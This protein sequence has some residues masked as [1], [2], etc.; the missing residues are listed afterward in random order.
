MHFLYYIIFNQVHIVYNYLHRKSRKESKIFAQQFKLV[1]TIEKLLFCCHSYVQANK[2]ALCLKIFYY[3]RMEPQHIFIYWNV[4]L[5]ILDQ[6]FFCSKCMFIYVQNL[7]FLAYFVIICHKTSRKH[8][9][10]IYA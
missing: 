4:L 6:F 9:F 1:L 2:K 3:R 7:C 5:D 8:I 10:C